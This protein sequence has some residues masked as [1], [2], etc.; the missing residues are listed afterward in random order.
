MKSIV[1]LGSLMLALTQVSLGQSMFGGESSLN[2]TVAGVEIEGTWEAETHDFGSIK[3]G[4]PVSHTFYVKNTGNQPLE[5]VRVI[6]ACGCTAADYTQEPI[7]PGETGYIKATYN[8]ATVG[9]FSKT[10]VVTTNEEDT[11]NTILRFKGE[12]MAKEGR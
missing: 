2:L 1:L 6:P 7:K 4:E 8:A 10:I 11:P 3:Q 12:V 9:Y 5:L